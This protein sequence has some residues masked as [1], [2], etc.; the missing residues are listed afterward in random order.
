MKIVRA[1][2]EWLRIAD[3]IF[4]SG[5]QID[6]HFEFIREIRLRQIHYSLWTFHSDAIV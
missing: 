1:Y 4:S 2:V 3:Q 6:E 5:D